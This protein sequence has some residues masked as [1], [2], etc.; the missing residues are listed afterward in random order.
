[1]LK[2]GL[3]WTEVLT[4]LLL[5]ALAP[6]LAR[7]VNSIGADLPFILCQAVVLL[8]A[9]ALQRAPTRASAVRAGIVLGFMLWLSISARTVAVAFL[10]AIVLADFVVHRRVRPTLLVPIL[11]AVALWFMQSSL[12]GQGNS[13]GYIAS[14][15]FFDVADTARTLFGR[16]P[17]CCSNRRCPP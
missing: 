13:Y 5:F 12:V 3:A 4:S 2:S 10:P 9:L 8:A 1:M 14:Y 11:V 6:A 16:S 15:K 17:T 7:D